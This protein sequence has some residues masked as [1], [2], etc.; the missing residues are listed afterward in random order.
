MKCSNLMPHRPIAALVGGFCAK[1]GKVM[2]HAGAWR[3]TGEN[4]AEEKAK[5]LQE[6]G[7]HLVD[8]PAK[9][10][11]ELKKLLSSS[12]RDVSKIVSKPPHSIEGQMLN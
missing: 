10:G 1:E 12:G 5:I 7:A 11:N 2:G 9:F 6:A 8:H 3:G 4:S